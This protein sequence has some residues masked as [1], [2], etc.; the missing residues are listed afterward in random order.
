[1]ENYLHTINSTVLNISILIICFFT[2]VIEISLLLTKASS[3]GSPHCPL[4]FLRTSRLCLSLR[5][6]QSVF[7]NLNLPIF[8]FQVIVP[9]CIYWF[10]I[11]VWIFLSWFF[12]LVVCCSQLNKWD[13]KGGYT[14]AI[15]V[16]II[17]KLNPH[18]DAGLIAFVAEV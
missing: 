12:T 3:A 16:R 9:F 2:L 7:H 8:Q 1:M 10:K 13:T 11:R 18:R 5:D 17:C 4:S 14:S 6:Q 15:H